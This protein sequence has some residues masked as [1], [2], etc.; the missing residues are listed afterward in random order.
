[1]EI[2][3]FYSEILCQKSFKSSSILHWVH[4]V[5]T[6]TVVFSQMIS[7]VKYYS[8]I[9]VLAALDFNGIF[10][11]RAP[12]HGKKKNSMLKKMINYELD[13]EDIHL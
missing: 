10:K 7:H 9:R 11:V 3:M 8:S 1:M 13:W 4:M 12:T 2:I 6:N 5:H